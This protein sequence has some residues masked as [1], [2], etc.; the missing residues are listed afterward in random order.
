MAKKLTEEQ[1]RVRRWLDGMPPLRAGNVLSEP[2]WRYERRAAVYWQELERLLDEQEL[3]V[4]QLGP[5]V[6]VF[7]S[8]TADPQC[9]GLI[10][11]A[12]AGDGQ[13]ALVLLEYLEEELADIAV[14]PELRLWANRERLEQEQAEVEQVALQVAEV[15]LR[16]LPARRAERL[17]VLAALISQKY[18]EVEDAAL[19]TLQLVRECGQF[20]A[21]AKE[22]VGHGHF[23]TWLA[24]EV[25]EI[26]AR[27]AEDYM[28]VYNHWGEITTRANPQRAADLSIRGALRYLTAPPYE[29]NAG[30]PNVAGGLDIPTMLADAEDTEEVEA[31][32]RA[33]QRAV[34]TAA[35]RQEAVAE[36]QTEAE[37]AARERRARED[38]RRE[39]EARVEAACREE[40]RE[41]NFDL[42]AAEEGLLAEL[43][44]LRDRWPAGRRDE[45]VPALRRVIR[46]FLGKQT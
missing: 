18:K 23:L 38:A 42:Q 8:R 35:A 39:E 32:R 30:E 24:R 28:R 27:T 6:F 29:Y 14:S 43:R 22:K 15:H 4:A 20:L 10:E 45:F 13:A 11:T 40:E 36:L 26:R 21:E 31:A 19:G 17:R 33:H 1:Q 5:H 12:A 16:N 2:P 34:N 37:K 9:W 3:G 7:P 44:R 25:P 46:C 41:Q